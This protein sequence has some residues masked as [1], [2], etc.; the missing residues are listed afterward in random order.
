[1]TIILAYIP[2]L[3]RGYLKFLSKHKE[4]DLLFL[5]PKEL[6]IKLAPDVDYL[7]KDIRALDTELIEAAL[8]SWK[9]LPKIEILSQEKLDKL[10]KQTSLEIIAPDEDIT[11]QV[12][13]QY[14]PQAK[15][16]FDSI[17]LRYDR[18]KALTPQKVDADQVIS[19]AK[20]DQKMMQL[21]KNS[22]Q[23]SSDWWRQVG[24]VLV[25]KDGKVISAGT[26]KHK[27]SDQTPYIMGDT[28]G[29]FHKG[30]HMELSTAAHAE[31]SLI[32]QAA[33]Q[34][35]S[36]KDAKLYVTD[37]PCPYCARMVAMSGI[38]QLFFS[39]GYA[40]MDGQEMLKDVGIKIIKVE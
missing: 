5:V 31:S 36:L 29:L 2:V 33:K 22:A 38:K 35:I 34:G 24:A 17:F 16:T 39:K 26:N 30:Q 3:H 6:V 28:R 32:A 40:V 14:L 13:G 15:T 21:A 7:H 9:I 23:K 25:S 8:K 27:P 37:F 4:A 1:M 18:K 12:I 19:K 10:S 11:R 20:F